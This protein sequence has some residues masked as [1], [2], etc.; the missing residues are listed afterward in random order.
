TRSKELD[1]PTAMASGG[2]EGAAGH[3]AMLHRRSVALARSDRLSAVSGTSCRQDQP[4]TMDVPKIL[5]AILVA[6]LGYAGGS[7]PVGVLVARS[8][9]GPDPRTI[10][11]GRTG[12]TNALRALGPRG[13]A[14][15]LLGDLL[16]GLLPVLVARLVGGREPPRGGGA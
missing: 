6:A 13:A 11:S 14:L 3:G 2:S 16:K 10:G 5:L 7:L 4:R 1:E 9:G 8:M 15:V 12:T